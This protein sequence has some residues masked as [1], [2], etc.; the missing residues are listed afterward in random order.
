MALLLAFGHVAPALSLRFEVATVDHGLRL[1]AAADAQFVAAA[2]ERVGVASHAVRVTLA[3]GPSLEARARHARYEALQQ[4]RQKQGLT[5]LLTAHTASDQAE[6]VVMRLSRGSS[7][8]GVGA[9]RQTRAD[10]VARPLLFA[11]RGE[12]EGYLAGLGADFRHDSMNDDLRFQRVKVRQTV[13]PVIEAAAPGATRALARFADLA[14]DD[15][16]LLNRHAHAALKR[17]RWPADGSLDRV[18]FCAL[19]RPIARRV[20]A[21]FLGGQGLEID[22]E[23]IAEVLLAAQQKRDAPL[24]NDRVLQCLH[25]R[26][27]VEAAPVRRIHQTS[28]S[29]HR[30]GENS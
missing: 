5:W 4:I 14:S 2:A 8:T 29:A 11:T 12:V 3:D 10:G 26:M 19:E 9:I 6:T 13:L 17:I 1:E 18:G 16:E 7:L 25:G 23:L 15:D 20:A 30:R 28:S 27:S 24:P 21:L 22:A